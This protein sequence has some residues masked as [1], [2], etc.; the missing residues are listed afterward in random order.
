[1]ICP[2]CGH[3]NIE[4]VDTC[5]ECQ[6][7]LVELSR[8]QRATTVERTLH[9]L[10]LEAVMTK[11]PV[12]VTPETTVGECLKILVDRSI[13]CL[14]VADQGRLVGIFSERDALMRL[15]SSAANLHSRSIAEFMTPAPETLTADSRLALALHKMDIGGYRHVPVLDENEQIAGIVSVRDALHIITADLVATGN[16]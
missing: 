9:R 10:R 16:A 5:E 2:H 11:N 1:M 4:G 6:Q 7:S 12:T 15:N 3:V 13:G 8:P 14:L